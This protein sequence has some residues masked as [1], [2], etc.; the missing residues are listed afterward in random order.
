MQNKRKRGRP[1]SGP[2]LT[3]SYGEGDF[4]AYFQRVFGI[5]PDDPALTW[6]VPF[7]RCV[8]LCQTIGGIAQLAGVHRNT[9][10]ARLVWVGHPGALVWAINRWQRRGARLLV[11]HKDPLHPINGSRLFA[12]ILQA[13]QALRE[14]KAKPAARTLIDEQLPRRKWRRQQKIRHFP[15]VELISP[16]LRAD[17]ARRKRV[18]TAFVYRTL[19]RVTVRQVCAVVGMPY[20]Q[21]YRWRESLPLAQ[22]KL[23]D[24]ALRPE[25]PVPSEPPAPVV[26]AQTQEP[27]YISDYAGTIDAANGWQD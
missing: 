26:D 22:R 5:S 18:G 8:R 11:R 21:F 23:L 13:I 14:V 15:G 24:A 2:D 27:F 7:R 6:R 4:V 25:K 1:V 12:E 17:V 9:V 20:R 19:H 3:G 16:E 10:R